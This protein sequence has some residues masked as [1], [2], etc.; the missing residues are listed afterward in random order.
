MHDSSSF[1]KTDIKP[2]EDNKNMPIG[3]DQLFEGDHL[4]V[5]TTLGLGRSSKLNKP[6]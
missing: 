6:S 5:H 4:D 1:D 3:A 2:I